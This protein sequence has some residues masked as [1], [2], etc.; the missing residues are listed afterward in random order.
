M[1]TKFV[2]TAIFTWND[3]SIIDLIINFYT[4]I[5]VYDPHLFYAVPTGFIFHSLVTVHSGIAF[6]ISGECNAALV[7]CTRQALLEHYYGL[8]CCLGGI[9]LGFGKELNT[10]NHQLER[11]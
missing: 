11:H 6:Y 9:A 10:L 1:Y 5:Y 2:L 3:N 4:N 8:K 7:T